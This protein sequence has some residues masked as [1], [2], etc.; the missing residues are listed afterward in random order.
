[1]GIARK[2]STKRR[3]MWYPIPVRTSR[4]IERRGVDVDRAF[5]GFSFGRAPGVVR[6]WII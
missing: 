5:M 6:G 1:M 2:Y 3:F 4:I